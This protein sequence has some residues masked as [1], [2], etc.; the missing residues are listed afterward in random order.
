MNT[1]TDFMV[2]FTK[3][4]ESDI[5]ALSEDQVELLSTVIDGLSKILLRRLGEMR[6]LRAIR[7]D[8]NN[9]R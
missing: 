1:V 5:N 2:A 6:A 7:E 4:E 9:V 8:L 3:M